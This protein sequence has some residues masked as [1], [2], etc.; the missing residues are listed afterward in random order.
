MGI[1]TNLVRYLVIEALIDRNRVKALLEYVN[2]ESLSRAA[3]RYGLHR[4][5]LRSMVNR[6]RY[7]KALGYGSTI[8]EKFAVYIIPFVLEVVDC[9]VIVFNVKHLAVVY[10]H[11]DRD[12][13][14]YVKDKV[15]KVINVLRQCC[16]YGVR[17]S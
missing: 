9:E 15:S 14:S 16:R 5:S 3:E 7:S 1:V 13:D 6:L 12:H 10:N 11:I 4:G 2:G 8:T 17:A